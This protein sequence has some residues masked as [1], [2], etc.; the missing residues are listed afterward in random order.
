MTFCFDYF[1]WLF[2]RRRFAGISSILT[3]CNCSYAHRK[4]VNN[5]RFDGGQQY[6]T[7]V[8]QKP[9]RFQ[10]ATHQRRIHLCTLQFACFSLKVQLL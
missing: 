8:W 4:I 5:F 1:Q 7:K 9:K 10:M 3:F 6:I 2:E